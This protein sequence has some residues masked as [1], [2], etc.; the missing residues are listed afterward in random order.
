MDGGERLIF[1]VE[2]IP[3]IYD[4]RHPSYRLNLDGKYLLC[5]KTRV[6]SVEMGFKVVAFCV[7]NVSSRSKSGFPS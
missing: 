5:N 7:S 2:K 6:S 4:T 3:L 1:E